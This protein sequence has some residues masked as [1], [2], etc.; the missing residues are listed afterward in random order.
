M[1]ASASI[2]PGLWIYCASRIPC[3][4]QEFVPSCGVHAHKPCDAEPVGRCCGFASSS[5]GSNVA[6]SW[7]LCSGSFPLEN[8]NLPRQHAWYFLARYPVFAKHAQDC[9]RN[10][11][12]PCWQQL[13][14]DLQ[15]HS[16]VVCCALLQL[17][18]GWVL[19]SMMAFGSIVGKAA[20][21]MMKQPRTAT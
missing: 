21:S 10:F 18:C 7:L 16:A 13:W 2:F 12:I 5:F 6:T 8:S 9:R 20:G 14:H 15:L 17:L 1:R 4:N 11:R 3:L 19:L